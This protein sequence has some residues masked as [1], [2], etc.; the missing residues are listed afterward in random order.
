MC[1]AISIVALAPS[2]HAQQED[3]DA[4]IQPAEPDYRL[5]NLPTTLRLPKFRGNFELTHRFGGN[6]EEGDFGDQLANLF[7]MDQGAAV[8]LEFRFAVARHVQAVVYRTSF[9]KDIW[10]YGKYDA[11]HQDARMPLSISALLG[12]EGNNNFQQDYM[13]SLGVVLSRNFSDRVAAYATPMWVHN[14]AWDVGQNRDTFMVGVG[15]R[16]RF[17]SKTYVSAEVTPRVS[18]Y[19]PGQTEYGFG[20]EERVGGHFFQLNFTNSQTTTFGQIARGGLPST[21]YLGFNLARK[22]Y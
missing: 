9:E 4:T 2:A 20:I 10:F 21:L 5:I 18:G 19:M 17:L 12:I 11:I 8:G 22:F 7:G 14:T 13:P 6:L 1:L 15:A 3:D 16:Y